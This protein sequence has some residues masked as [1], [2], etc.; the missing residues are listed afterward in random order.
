VVTEW[1][2]APTSW[3]SKV[4]NTIHL[5]DTHGVGTYAG[6]NDN[7]AQYR[8]IFQSPWMNLGEEL[9]N[10]LKMLKRMSAIL[11][12][13]QATSVVFK[14]AVDFQDSGRSITRSAADLAGDEWN[15]GEWSVAEWS[16]ADALRIMSVPARD[17]GQYYRIGIEANVTGEFAVQQ[18]ELTTKI[19]RLA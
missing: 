16:G 10:R 4:D 18:V 7:T 12:I 1:D 9:A 19:G 2:L 17:K 5:G 14:W 3:L 6:F 13:R 11:F 8:F 15:V